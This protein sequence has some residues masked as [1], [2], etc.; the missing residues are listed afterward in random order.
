ML[1]L[2][3]QRRGS[4]SIRF[5]ASLALLATSVTVSKAELAPEPDLDAL[6]SAWLLSEKALQLVTELT[7][8]AEDGIQS[9]SKLL[10]DCKARPVCEFSKER[11]LFED[12]LA[13]A[14]RQQTHAADLFV[15]MEARKNELQGQIK[16]RSGVDAA[17]RCVVTG[18]D[19][20]AVPKTQPSR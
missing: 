10:S 12:S 20:K 13:R 16:Q 14:R 7:T 6:C 11:S 5:A 2:V 4:A 15:Q 19:A 3:G 8:I 1:R 9:S 18:N 17:S